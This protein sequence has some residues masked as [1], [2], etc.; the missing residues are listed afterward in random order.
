MVVKGEPDKEVGKYWD[1][2]ELFLY[3]LTVLVHGV[4]YNVKVN[5][6]IYQFGF[7]FLI[8]SVG[9]DYCHEH[10]HKVLNHWHSHLSHEL[11]KVSLGKVS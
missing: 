4:S 6:A 10:G 3:F 2:K 1:L 9:V 5:T 11:A 8:V 7:F